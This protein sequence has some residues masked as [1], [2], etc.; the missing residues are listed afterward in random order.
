MCID[1]LD[2]LRARI[3]QIEG[4]TSRFSNTQKPLSKSASSD[5]TDT[6]LPHAWSFGTNEI[7]RFFSNGLSPHALHEITPAHYQ[8]SWATLSFALALLSRRARHDQKPILWCSSSVDLSEFGDLY[9]HGFQRFNLDP[10]RFILIE[11][12]NDRETAFVLEETLKSRQLCA[13]LGPMKTLNFTL[14][15]RLS[16][17]AA[18]GQTPALLITKPDSP[19]IRTAASRWQVAA[20]PPDETVF[21]AFSSHQLSWQITL[22]RNR[23]GPADKKWYLEF[24]SYAPP[25]DKSSKKAF[26]FTHPS[27]FRNRKSKTFESKTQA[28]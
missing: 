19:G 22:I 3:K 26:R 27:P 15:R 21:T 20:L 28:A 24:P 11:T 17:M 18:K 9:G 8:D 23:Q 6:H 4:R 16:L 10:G 5:K 1:Q 2:N 14:S 25:L 7:D 12:K 13:V